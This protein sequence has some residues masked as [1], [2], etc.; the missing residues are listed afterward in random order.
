MTPRP[1]APSPLY[2]EALL[3]QPWDRRLAY[4]I[5]RAIV[6]HARLRHVTQEVLAAVDH[7]TREY[8]CV[9]GPTRV[10]KSTLVRG[11]TKTLGEAGGPRMLADAGHQPVVV[12]EALAPIHGRFDWK[13]LYD[14]G[15]DA[16]SDPFVASG[17]GTRPQGDLLRRPDRRGGVARL[18]TRDLRKALVQG[19][20]AR[21]PAAV[22]IDEANEIAEASAGRRYREQVR[23]IR[24]LAKQMDVVVVLVGTYELL[25][26]RNLTGQLA[27]RSLNIHFPRYDATAPQDLDDFA[28]A[29]HTLQLYLPLRHQPDLLHHLDYCYLYS[30]GCIG[31]LKD[32]LTS[33]LKIALRAGDETLTLAHLEQ[34]ALPKQTCKQLIDE[35]L[36]HERALRDEDVAEAEM[37]AAYG[38][39]THI[40]ALPEPA[41]AGQVEPRPTA[42]QRTSHRR[43]IRDPIQPDD[44]EKETSDVTP[45]T[46]RL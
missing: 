42:R 17:M 1:A 34:C 43:P 21:S 41:A 20:R 40:L 13:E 25:R 27:C 22:I 44:E 4:F 33:A 19:V 5:E 6:A 39:G 2:P 7:P 12:I 37:R 23:H 30:V 46:L 15:L 3:A 14:S 38:L 8:I 45:R 26:L 24:S 11:L 18:P 32:W 28:S 9:Y 36:W 35:A 16:I 31:I 29:L 10:G